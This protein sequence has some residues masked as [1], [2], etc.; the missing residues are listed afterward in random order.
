M[1]DLAFFCIF[2]W[3]TELATRR[4]SM[5]WTCP[6]VHQMWLRSTHQGRRVHCQMCWWNPYWNP[7]QRQR[8]YLSQVRLS[9]KTT[10]PL[11]ILRFQNSWLQT[12]W[13]FKILDPKYWVFRI[14]DPKY[15]F[16]R[17][18]THKNIWCL[19]FSSH[20][21]LF[22]VYL[23]YLIFSSGLNQNI[24]I[25][26]FVI[27]NDCVFRILHPHNI[28]FSK[29]LTHKIFGFWNFPPTNN[30]LLFIYCI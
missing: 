13:D 18:L 29:F 17:L 22:I 10:W 24:W 7:T 2:R 28:Y 14:L 6:L 5:D 11:I 16:S 20:Q 23:L 1:I 4:W 15:C 3:I 27:Q 21:Q 30:Y 9:K 19:E 12:I 26:E 8:Q 25:S